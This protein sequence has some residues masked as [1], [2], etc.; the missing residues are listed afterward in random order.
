MNE[1]G[2]SKAQAKRTEQSK[3]R[4]GKCE[5]GVDIEKVIEEHLGIFPKAVRE[6]ILK[7]I[8]AD[9]KDGIVEVTVR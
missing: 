5:T 4:P 8:K 1:T 2:E 6:E 3:V 7:K 9:L